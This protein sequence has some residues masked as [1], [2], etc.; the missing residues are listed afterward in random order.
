MAKSKGEKIADNIS[1]KQNILVKQWVESQ[2]TMDI[3]IDDFNV[4]HVDLKKIT[5]RF[6]KFWTKWFTKSTIPIING[7]KLNEIREQFDA[8]VKIHYELVAENEKV[9]QSI[10]DFGTHIETTFS[11]MDLK[12]MKEDEMT[13]ILTI[14]ENKIMIINE[15]YLSLILKYDG[16]RMQTDDIIGQ[17]KDYKC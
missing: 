6:I 9:G 15:N 11:L 17:L 1:R 2:K 4:C 7:E 10:V 8:N 14:F 12:N 16:L 13:K 5:L 3:L